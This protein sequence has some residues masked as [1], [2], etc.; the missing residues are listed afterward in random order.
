MWGTE[1]RKDECIALPISEQGDNVWSCIILDHS[2]YPIFL[3]DGSKVIY[4]EDEDEENT[5]DCWSLEAESMEQWLENWLK[6]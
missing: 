4:D 3:Y 5:D 1:V 6:E 2:E